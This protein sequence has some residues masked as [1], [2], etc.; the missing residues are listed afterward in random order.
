MYGA[1]A[2]VDIPSNPRQRR[3][4]IKY[5]LRLR[6]L[7]LA[8]LARQE[9]VA[10]TTAKKCLYEPYPKWERKIAK[11]LGVKPERLWPERYDTGGR[12][13]RRMGRPSTR[14]LCGHRP[15]RNTQRRAGGN[16]Q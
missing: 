9:R 12:P 4:W 16:V 2:P 1:M 7:S 14:K 5:Q 3:E 10:R 15:K 8:A 13:N 6:G 11:R